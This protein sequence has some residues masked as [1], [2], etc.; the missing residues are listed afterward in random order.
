MKPADP[1]V[2]VIDSPETAATA[3]RGTRRT[4]LAALTEPASAAGL[5]RRLGLPRQ[6][7][8]YHLKV[9]EQCGLLECVEER[10][11]GNCTERVLRATARSFVISPDALGAL[12]PTA[13]AA[14]DR[15]S[16]SYVVAVAARTI[17]EVS[18]LESRARS[19]HK[20]VSTLAID[21]EIRFASA[22]TRAAFASELTDRVAE[23][24]AKYHDASAPGGR[25]FRLVTVAHPRPHTATSDTSIHPDSSPA[26]K[27]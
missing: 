18:A 4:F 12:G 3:L 10:R 16:A 22:E 1:G 6:R 17:S 7:L 8:N 14:H 27:E 20:R 2:T 15:L 25:H 19:E 26:N 23:L 11:K 24:V 9:L 5:A 21:S 13:E